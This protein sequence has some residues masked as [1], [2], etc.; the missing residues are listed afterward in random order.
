[1]AEAKLAIFSFHVELMA[2]EVSLQSGGKCRIR[3]G[4][5]R[6]DIM[7]EIGHF[8]NRTDV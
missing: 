2:K 5:E 4:M 3:I 8:T 7:K 1:M 6:D